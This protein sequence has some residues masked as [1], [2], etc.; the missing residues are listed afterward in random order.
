MQF[1]VR[2]AVAGTASFGSLLSSRGGFRGF[3]IVACSRSFGRRQI[4]LLRRVCIP[5]VRSEIRTSHFHWTWLSFVHSLRGRVSL[6]SDNGPVFDRR[7][8]DRR[9]CFHVHDL[10][11]GI[12]CLGNAHLVCPARFW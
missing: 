10:S 1:A 7:Y 8:I 11:G 9:I 5:F 2:V 6:R 12:S 4:H 3:A